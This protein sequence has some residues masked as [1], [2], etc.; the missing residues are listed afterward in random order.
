VLGCD[1]PETPPQLGRLDI[2]DLAGISLGAAV[3]ARHPAG[4]PL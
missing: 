1:L 3:L 4:E 2:G